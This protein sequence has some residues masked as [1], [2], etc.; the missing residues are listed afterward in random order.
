VVSNSAISAELLALNNRAD[1]D[2]RDSA[3]STSW[4]QMQNWCQQNG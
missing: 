1:L 2:S 4:N 3:D